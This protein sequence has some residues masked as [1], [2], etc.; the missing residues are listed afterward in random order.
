M[1]FNCC[2]FIYQIN[3]FESDSYQSEL[4]LKTKSVNFIKFYFLIISLQII[5]YN[6]FYYTHK[7]YFGIIDKLFVNY[8]S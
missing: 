5:I 3:I 6:S 2:N 8:L 4:N 1:Q 7:L